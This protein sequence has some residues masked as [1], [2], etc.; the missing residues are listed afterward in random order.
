MGKFSEVAIL[1]ELFIF[2]RYFIGGPA[3]YARF[4]STWT[5]FLELL[6]VKRL[7]KIVARSTGIEPISQRS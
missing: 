3:L 5:M 2:S 6:G 7:L 4:R 1:F